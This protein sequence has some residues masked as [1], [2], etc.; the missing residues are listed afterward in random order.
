MTYIDTQN[1]HGWKEHSLPKALFND[2]QTVFSRVYLQTVHFWIP[3]PWPRDT[4]GKSSC[5]L[6]WGQSFAGRAP[7]VW[8]RDHDTTFRTNGDHGK[9]P[10]W[11]EDTSWNGCFSIVTVMLVFGGVDSRSFTIYGR[12]QT[13]SK[14][15]GLFWVI[16]TLLVLVVCVGILLMTRKLPVK[17]T[18]NFWGVPTRNPKNSG[19]LVQEIYE[20]FQ[21]MW[22]F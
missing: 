19:F 7:Q 12:D 18:S 8:N 10:F 14:N 13:S 11:I 15:W 4:F 6:A 21:G 16:S 9:A 17:G 3:I 1:L 2:F 20:Q 22:R 5:W